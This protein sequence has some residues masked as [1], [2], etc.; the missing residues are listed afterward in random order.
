MGGNIESVERPGATWRSKNRW[1]EQIAAII[2]TVSTGYAVRFARDGSSI[3]AWRGRISLQCKLHG[4]MGHVR[5]DG[6]HI[7]A[8]ATKKDGA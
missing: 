2:A 8:W 3:T 6:D 7:I 1:D 4:L 5:V